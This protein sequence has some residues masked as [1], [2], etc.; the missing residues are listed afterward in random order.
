MDTLEVLKQEPQVLPR[1][2]V[3]LRCANPACAVAF[4]GRFSR[5]IPA[6]RRCCSRR[7][8]SVLKGKRT[9]ALHC[10]AGEGNHNFK[11]WRSRDKRAYVNRYRAR[12][13]QIAR[14]HDA[15]KRALASGDLVRPDLCQ[16]CQK[17]P[18]IHSH[19]EDY[20][21]PLDVLFVCRPCHRV[22][23]A[24]RRLRKVSA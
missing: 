23:D 13:P 15:V 20:A 5:D 8:A 21:A 18:A 10:Q 22:L 9:A 1:R 2:L 16:R 4:F 12:N 24:E 3:A 17:A 14:A 11:G 19:H 7:C 6:H